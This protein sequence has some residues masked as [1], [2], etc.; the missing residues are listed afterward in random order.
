[1][2]LFTMTSVVTEEKGRRRPMGCIA[3]CLLL[4]AFDWILLQTMIMDAS[5]D[6]KQR[7]APALA[8]GRAAAWQEGS[9]VALLL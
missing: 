1:M 5:T 7:I 9:S 6:A 3:L 2:K 8:A 4:A